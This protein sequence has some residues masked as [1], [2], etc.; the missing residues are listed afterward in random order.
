MH[1]CHLTTVGRKTGLTGEI[2]LNCVE[3]GPDVAL[4]ASNNGQDH[5]PAWWLNLQANPDATVRIG[6]AV[7]AVR[8]R[9]ATPAEHARIWARFVAGEPGYAE[10]PGRTSRHITVVVLEP[11]P[12]R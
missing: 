4:V 6:D 5:E 2:A 9:A 11:H 3:D 7:R 10:Y 12:E 8:A 1:P